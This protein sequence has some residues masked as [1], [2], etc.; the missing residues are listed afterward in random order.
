M[1]VS[2]RYNGWF[3]RQKRFSGAI[4]ACQ[5]IQSIRYT[6]SILIEKYFVTFLRYPLTKK[7]FMSFVEVQ[8]EISKG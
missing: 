6:L 5:N 4:K 3:G 8:K 1:P 2:P 7:T